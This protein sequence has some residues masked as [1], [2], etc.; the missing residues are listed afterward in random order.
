MNAETA[1]AVFQV[2]NV[3]AALK[4][5]LDVLGF[6]KE[7]RF[8]DYAGVKIGQ[9]SMHLSGHSIHQ[10]PV[11]AGMIY[12]SCD[13]VDTY[14]TDIKARGATIKTEPQTWD[15][16]MRDFVVVDPDGNHLTFGCPC[17]QV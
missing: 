14:H 8:G 2:S 5:Y 4:H 3:D 12:I 17:G 10:R 13:E 16:G 6:S 15:Y 9:V 7:F 11:G 1:A